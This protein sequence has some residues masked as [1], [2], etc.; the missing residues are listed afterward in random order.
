MRN[1]CISVE[2]LNHRV[3][4]VAAGLDPGNSAMEA[5]VST[6]HRKGIRE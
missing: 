2:D 5:V 4:G 3:P 1:E 6:V